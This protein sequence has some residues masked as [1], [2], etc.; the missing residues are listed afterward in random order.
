M[1]LL[2]SI[3]KN[4][5]LLT[6]FE[7][8]KFIVITRK[9]YLENRKTYYVIDQKVLNTDYLI[10]LVKTGYTEKPISTNWEDIVNKL[11]MLKVIDN[12]DKGYYCTQC[13]KFSKKPMME[14]GQDIA[15]LNNNFDIRQIVNS[16]YD[17]CKG[18]D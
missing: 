4:E 14:F 2:S 10:P 17:G 13:S 16:H 11:P 18:W 5:D 1:K 12:R 7:N 9:K 3:Q 6:L 15:T 8:D